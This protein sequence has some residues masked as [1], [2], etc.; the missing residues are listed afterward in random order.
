MAGVRPG[1]PGHEPVDAAGRGHPT[2]APDG[3]AALVRVSAGLH[4]AEPALQRARNAPRPPDAGPYLVPD[5]RRQDRGV[6]GPVGLLP[7][8]PPALGPDTGRTAGDGGT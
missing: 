3:H 6:P 2:T 7:V 1:Q 4:S 5:R 8:P